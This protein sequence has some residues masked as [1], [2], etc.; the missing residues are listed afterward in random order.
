MNKSVLCLFAA[1]FSAFF[2]MACNSA[3][4]AD[5]NS[6]VP[7]PSQAIS[8]ILANQYCGKNEK[9][10]ILINNSRQLQQA[11]G[12]SPTLTPDKTNDLKIDFEKF[13][14]LYAALGKKPS[15]GYTLSSDPASYT[16]KSNIMR[17]TISS[18][19]PRPDQTTAQVMT[20]PCL[21]LKIERKSV[22]SIEVDFD[23][24]IKQFN[25]AR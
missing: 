10:I 11:L 2:L 13:L 6:S 23:R 12:T 17:L 15:A 3:S 9:Q 21:L 25:L 19:S 1:A 24:Q 22:K 8:T 5:P 16:F 14:L 18:T 20:S 4:Q 7:T